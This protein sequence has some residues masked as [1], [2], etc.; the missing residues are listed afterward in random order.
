MIGAG[1][2]LLSLVAVAAA[3]TALGQLVVVVF[4][5]RTLL[6]AYN[7]CLPLLG[8]AVMLTGA[9]AVED[10]ALIAGAG[11]ATFVLS[12]MTFSAVR[13]R[14]HAL[15]A[16]GELR[17]HELSRRWVW[18]PAPTRGKGERRF[19]GRQDEL[20]HSSRGATMSPTCR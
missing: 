12:A 9:I 17:E 11:V 4:H 19:V 18:Q 20:V 5:R 2:H 16:G 1:E 6:I 8:A 7:L 10:R 15:G 13:R 14:V 3:L